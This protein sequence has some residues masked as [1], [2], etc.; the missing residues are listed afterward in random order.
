MNKWDGFETYASEKIGAYSEYK[1]EWEVQRL[2]IR[3]K[4][5]GMIGHD[6]EG[7]SII[8]LK[9]APENS[10]VLRNMYPDIRPGYY[11]NKT[12]WV[13]I[14]L[15]GEVPEAVIKDVIDE[16][17]EL[18][19]NSFSKKIQQEIKSFDLVRD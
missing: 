15:N 5:F 6:K 1:L 2:M 12:L 4:M 16:S 19:L 10:L 3:D 18:I 14:D 7:R 9:V 17:Y 8:T 11:M 13:S